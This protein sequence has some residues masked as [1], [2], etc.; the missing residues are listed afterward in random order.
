MRQ[1]R[2]KNNNLHGDSLSV[3]GTSTIEV[4]LVTRETPQRHNIKEDIEKSSE[5]E[6]SRK[7][8]INIESQRETVASNYRVIAGHSS[9]THHRATLSSQESITTTQERPLTMYIELLPKD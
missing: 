9:Y 1:T 2:N 7:K 4:W 8:G 5:H 6:M 3:K